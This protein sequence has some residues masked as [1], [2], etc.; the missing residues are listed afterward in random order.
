M[1]LNLAGAGT[2]TLNNTNN[3]T[4]ATTVSNG[5]LLVNGSLSQSPV[6]VLAGGTLG[7]GGSLGLAPTL[8]SGANLS[9]G[10]GIGG[11]GTL[12]VTGSLTES[13]GIINLFDLSNDPTGLVKTND[14]IKVIGALTV[15]G[16]NTILVNLLNGP[17]L[18][19]TYTLIKY[20]SFAGSL[21]NF[22]LINANGVLTNPPG[23]IDIYV[24]NVRTPANLKWAGDGVNNTWDT[25][26]T[27]NWLNG[28]SPDVFYFF[29]SPIFRRHRLHQSGDQ[30]GRHQHARGRD[31]QRDEE[32]HLGG[33]GRISGY[34]T[35]TKTNSGTLTILATNDFAGPTV[36]GGGTLSV[37]VI[38][39][40]DHPQPARRG[41]RQPR[42]SG[43]QRRHLALHR[44]QRQHRPRRDAESRRR[45]H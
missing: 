23:E 32:L 30:P 11:A 43:F 20:G 14:Q 10:N 15:S 26:T 42:Q 5:T 6:T 25:G 33:S 28:A 12:T 7:G 40:G 45:N 19:G 37:P 8:N 41:G 24:N 17:L 9:P 35:L 22:T 3:F 29:D 27:T 34:G 1:T 31:L 13:G 18:N 36:I 16:K 21:T 38:A 2:L 44:R 4:G 39:N